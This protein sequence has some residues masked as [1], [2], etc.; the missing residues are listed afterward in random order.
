MPRKKGSDSFVKQIGVHAYPYGNVGDDL[1]ILSLCNRYPHVQFHLA[2]DT[3]FAHAFVRIPNLTIYPTRTLTGR[4]RTI[5]QKKYVFPAVVEKKIDATVY[6]GGSLFIEQPGWEK[7]FAQMQRR[8]KQDLPFFIIGA[9][10]G[11]YHSEHFRQTHASFFSKITDICFRDH[12]SH[13][14]FQDL[15]HAR[16]APDV[17]FHMYDHHEKKHNPSKKHLL[18]SVIYPSIRSD[19]ADIDDRYFSAIAQVVTEA[20]KKNWDV[21]L[22]AFCPYEKDDQAIEHIAQRIPTAVQK[23]ISL[24]MYDGN[25][26]TLKH[27]FREATHVIATRF[28][29]MIL[30]WIYE[31]NVLPISYSP[32]METVLADINYDGYIQRIKEISTHMSRHFFMNKQ[33]HVPVQTLARQ[34]ENHFKVLDQFLHENA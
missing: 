21:T 32:K 28:H 12:A 15:T 7:S 25:I 33:T 14:L 23:K 6:I 20:V 10:F 13:A 11:P 34:S 27:L 5:L 30:G 26:D 19:L 16:H 29:A 2:M 8:H 4:M 22:T 9:N 31:K 18:I 1:F 17:I 3:S 24:H